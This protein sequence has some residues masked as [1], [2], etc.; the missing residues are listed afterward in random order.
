MDKIHLVECPRDAM[1]GWKHE[2]TTEDKLGYLKTLFQVGFDT[3]DLGSFVSP[4]AVPQM[5]DTG[6]ILQLLEDEMI[7]P[8]DRTRSLVIVAN[9]RGA[10]DAAQFGV[11]DDMGFPLSLSESFQKRNTGASIE[12]AFSRLDAIQNICINSSKRLVVYLS[13]GFGNPYGDPY[14]PEMLMEFSDKLKSLMDIKVIALSDT[15]GSADEKTVYDAFNGVINELPTVEFGAH[16]HLNIIEGLGKIEAAINGGCRRFD[17]AIR[18][19]GGCPMAQD[20]LVGNAPTEH[21]IQLFEKKEL[22]TVPN[23]K[24]W[25]QAQS[26]AMEIFSVS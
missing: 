2:I 14:H 20:D 18:G 11:V 22:W 24:A 19:I 6:E 26:H 8:S 1:Q 15:V 3:L 23:P 4:K 10:Q 25:S 17:G 7:L 9:E 5:A 21:L 13:M 12:K 16:M